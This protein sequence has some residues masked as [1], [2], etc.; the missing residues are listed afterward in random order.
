MR[1]PDNLTGKAKLTI[2]F[3]DTSKNIV[4]ATTTYEVEIQAS[5][6]EKK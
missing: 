6:N 3:P 4:F 1:V 2:S 5:E